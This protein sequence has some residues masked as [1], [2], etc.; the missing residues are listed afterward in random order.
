MRIKPV[1]TEADYKAA[2]KRV[3]ALMDAAPGSTHE[4][5]L[6]RHPAVWAQLAGDFPSLLPRRRM[7]KD[8]Q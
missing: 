5:E 4:D 7:G 2:L 8:N 6:D 1:R 3:E